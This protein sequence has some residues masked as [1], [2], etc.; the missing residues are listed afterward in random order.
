[1]IEL[2]KPLT[3]FGQLYSE[4]LKPAKSL[5]T[6]EELIQRK[7]SVELVLESAGKTRATVNRISFIAKRAGTVGIAL[8]S[9]SPWS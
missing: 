9:S 2:R 8:K 1:M 7:G 6:L 3:P 4:I 5:P